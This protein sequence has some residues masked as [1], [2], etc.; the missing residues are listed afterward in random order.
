[1]LR[2]QTAAHTA[3]LHPTSG[4]GFLVLP[5]PE[6]DLHLAD[7]LP[8]GEEHVSSLQKSDYTAMLYELLAAGWRICDEGS[9]VIGELPDGRK[10][11]MLCAHALAAENPCIEDFDYAEERFI[12]LTH[13]RLD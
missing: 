13:A 5:D 3:Y 4:T 10:V 11:A 7:L 12:E 9:P 6:A 8:N 2:L 1:M